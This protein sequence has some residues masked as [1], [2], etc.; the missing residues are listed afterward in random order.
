MKSRI[1]ILIVG[2]VVGPIGRIMFQKHIGRLKR[3]HHADAVIVNGEN[4]SNTGRGIT[5]KIAKFFRH[6]GADMITSGNHIWAAKEIYGYLDEHTDLLRPA[7]FPSDC[8]GKGVGIFDVNGISVGVMNIQGQVFMQHFVD[9]PFKT[10]ESILTYLRSKTKIIVC[11]FHAE[12][13][14]EKVAM[15]FFLDGKVSAVVGT[16]THIQTADERVLPEGTAYITDLGMTGSLNSFIGMKKG[17]IMQKFLTQMPHKFE[18][19]TSPPV[20]LSGV[21]VEIDTATGKATHIERVRII[22]EDI[23]IDKEDESD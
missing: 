11:D 16:H 19:D 13:T 17:P 2:D 22:D 8:P 1:R 7:N 9:S 3:E 14:A 6:N 23:H 5:S 12:A 21:V 20:V 18:V 4:S 10:A 15:G